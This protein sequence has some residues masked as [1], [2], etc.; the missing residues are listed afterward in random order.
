METLVGE[1]EARKVVLFGGHRIGITNNKNYSGWQ[2]V[3]AAVN[4]VSGTEC[5]VPEL[6]VKWSDI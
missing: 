3:A 4:S 2:H 5:T 6:K 1:M